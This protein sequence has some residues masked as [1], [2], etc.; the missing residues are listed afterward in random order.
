LLPAAFVACVHVCLPTASFCVYVCRRM[1]A[2][3]HRNRR[4][5]RTPS[6]VSPP[7]VPGTGPDGAPSP[8]LAGVLRPLGHAPAPVKPTED[9]KTPYGCTVCEKAFRTQSDL[10]A[11]FRTHTGEKPLRCGFQGCPKSF[12]HRW[13]GRGGAMGQ[14]LAE[15]RRFG[16]SAGAMIAPR[17]V[18]VCVFACACACVYACAYV[19]VYSHI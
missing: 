11:H 18:R 9:V 3:Q 15:C 16:V 4:A 2:T 6:P 8:A 17:A 12:A 13:G 10:T 5:D 19:C 14:R 7:A 1:R